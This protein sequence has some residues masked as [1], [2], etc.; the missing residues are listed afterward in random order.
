MSNIQPLSIVLSDG[1]QVNNK[2]EITR[3]KNPGVQ[4]SELTSFKSL[5]E[6]LNDILGG[7]T[8]SQ[9]AEAIKSQRSNSQNTVIEHNGEIIASFG[10]NGFKYFSK[11]SD[12]ASSLKY[13]PLDTTA[14]IRELTA[15]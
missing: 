3:L 9:R 8:E 6:Q 7:L 2:S 13:S 11:N 4:F 10:D 12:G 5:G 1:Y 14:I 15:A